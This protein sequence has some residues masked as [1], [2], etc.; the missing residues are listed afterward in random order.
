MT[1][2]AKHRSPL[3]A[4]LYAGAVSA[5]RHRAASQAAKAR[6][7]T[8]R[9][10]SGALVRTGEA[11]IAGRLAEALATLADEIERGTVS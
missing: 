11:A 8:A 5:L 10:E 4:E 6:A 9:T 7:G 1:E 3:E 2:T